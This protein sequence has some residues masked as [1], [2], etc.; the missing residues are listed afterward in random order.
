M[1]ALAELTKV[2][3]PLPLWN[4]SFRSRVNSGQVE[5]VFLLPF[6]VA[7]LHKPHPPPEANPPFGAMRFVPLVTFSLAVFGVFLSV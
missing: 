3:P 1:V 2:F 5:D 4:V 7:C 6:C